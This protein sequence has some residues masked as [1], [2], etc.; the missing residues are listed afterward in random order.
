MTD[1]AN[2]PD[3]LKPSIALLSKLG[4]IV[5]HVEE[6]AGGSGHRFDADAIASLMTDPEVQ[7]WLDGMRWMALLPEKRS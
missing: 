4:S 3:P 6:I 1:I 7:L 5:V 2:K